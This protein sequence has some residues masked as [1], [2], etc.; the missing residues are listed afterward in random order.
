MSDEYV[1][2]PGEE[3]YFLYSVDEDDSNVPL[4]LSKGP[5]YESL[6]RVP[7]RKI[8]QNRERQ[9]MNEEYEKRRNQPQ[10]NT[11]PVMTLYQGNSP[12]FTTKPANSPPS[13]SGSPTRNEFGLGDFP[14]VS[15][16]PDQL[17]IRQWRINRSVPLDP[18]GSYQ[19]TD[20]SCMD[21]ARQMDTSE[22][23]F[24]D[25]DGEIYFCYPANVLQEYIGLYRLNQPFSRITREVD[26]HIT[27]A[28]GHDVNI[29]ELYA[30]PSLVGTFEAPR[31]IKGIPGQF[32]SLP[33]DIKLK[34]ME[35]LDPRDLITVC[36]LNMDNRRLCQ[37]PVRSVWRRKLQQLEPTL[38]FR[39][40][41][42]PFRYFMQRYFGGV[43][44]TLGSNHSGQ[45]G[46]FVSAR[47]TFTD[48]REMAGEITQEDLA[49]Q[50]QFLN[51]SSVDTN[52]DLQPKPITGGVRGG[53][54]DF[55]QISAVACGST[56]TLL[57]TVS[58]NVLG[59]GNNH[60][61]QLGVGQADTEI[62][63]AIDIGRDFAVAVACGDDHSAILLKSGRVLTFGNNRYGKLGR[64]TN[65]N[66]GGIS[67]AA[68]RHFQGFTKSTLPKADNIDPDLGN[69]PQPTEVAGIA[70]A[71]AIACGGDHTAVLLR[72]GQ[73]VTFGNNDSGQLG[74][75]TPPIKYSNIY[76]EK[77]KIGSFD[78]NP[79]PTMNIVSGFQ[80][81]CGRNH[82]V[83]VL[84]DGRVA[85][86]GA[87]KEGQL[88][89]V[90]PDDPDNNYDRRMADDVIPTVI[91]EFKTAVGVSCGWE[92]TAVVLQDGRVATFGNNERGQ[93]G[94]V[95]HRQEA[96]PRIIEGISSA[97]SV[98]C[99][100]SSTVVL[101][102]NGNVL[103]AG[104]IARV[105]YRDK[106][107]YRLKA[108]RGVNTAIAVA[109]G[110]AHLAILVMSR[111]GYFNRSAL[112]A[113]K[114]SLC[115]LHRRAL[116]RL[117]AR[118]KVPRG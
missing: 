52:I 113:E 112:R 41:R 76:G 94:R 67:P 59:F 30:G 64:N 86:F 103:I 102:K 114:G 57:T 58:G 79:A 95:V 56:F 82:T 117:T 105:N 22:L 66:V 100:Q 6:E 68:A 65:Q 104:E 46:R 111:H 107:N 16:G 19:V 89:R 99:G 18:G 17:N 54:L 71:V 106:P 118:H 93:L 78:V 55:P 53:V 1:L 62:P 33:S 35:A 3:D 87:N 50:D 44:L 11:G 96:V 24:I 8:L 39:R 81:A 23:N 29:K 12:V 32:N 77:P 49:R 63:T 47:K 97:T 90:T 91:P 83:V 28:S 74:R 115:G 9:R 98:S 61:G 31:T 51:R 21:Y 37:D 88:G 101:L 109:A 14:P 42:D 27:D 45:L 48:Y 85:S 72:N 84:A 70:D 26:R 108:V 15:N 110:G 92:H 4:V 20:E 80:I 13:K 116:A 69:S 36:N 38:D 34:I 7:F 75:E 43:L 10:S 2:N 73:V 60:A 25:E 40:V 5:Y